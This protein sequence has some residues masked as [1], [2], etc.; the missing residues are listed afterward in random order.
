MILIGCSGRRTKNNIKLHLYSFE[1]GVKLM[2]FVIKGVLSLYVA[3]DHRPLNCV[4]EKL[5][6][7]GRNAGNNLIAKAHV[8]T[9]S[10]R[11]AEDMKEFVRSAGCATETKERSANKKYVSHCSIPKFRRRPVAFPVGI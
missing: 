11:S 9:C 8:E 5:V 10:P 1:K 7:S 6:V 3:G 4:R 2:G